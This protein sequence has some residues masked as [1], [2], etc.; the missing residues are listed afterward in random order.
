MTTMTFT[1]F[2]TH[3]SDVIESVKDGETIAVTYG[4][5]GNSGLFC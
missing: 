4:K 5:K 2:T 3:F 1:Y